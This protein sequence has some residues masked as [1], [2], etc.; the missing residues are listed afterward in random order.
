VGCRQIGTVQLSY[1][2]IAAAVRFCALTTQW[3]QTQRAFALLKEHP[4]GSGLPK[5]SKPCMPFGC[6]ECGMQ[7]T[8]VPSWPAR[9]NSVPFYAQN[10]LDR[11]GVYHIEL[12]CPAC[13]KQVFVVW[14][15]DP[16]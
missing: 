4:P 8:R 11:R 14:D 13:N 3:Q 12:A 7:I 5:Y 16:R 2:Q 15:M 9:G 10:Q 6:P 1:S